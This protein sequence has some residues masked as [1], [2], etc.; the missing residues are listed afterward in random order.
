MLVFSFYIIGRW[1]KVVVYLAVLSVFQDIVWHAFNENCE[2]KIVQRTAV[3]SS[4][5]GMFQI[6]YK[7]CLNA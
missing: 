7:R 6:I 2:A 5:Y 3:S 4:H 1:E